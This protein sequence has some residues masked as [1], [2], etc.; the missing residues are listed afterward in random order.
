VE[1]SGGL[2]FRYI[3]GAEFSSSTTAVLDFLE[4]FRNYA[5]Q[6]LVIFLFLMFILEE[7]ALSFHDGTGN[8][9]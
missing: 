4:C 8:Y 1:S 9:I 2:W 6:C 7:L 5:A 3:S